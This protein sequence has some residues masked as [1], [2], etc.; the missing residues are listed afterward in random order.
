MRITIN[1][2][3]LCGVVA[4]ASVANN[5]GSST[6]LKFSSTSNIVKRHAADLT[7][8]GSNV[9]VTAGKVRITPCTDD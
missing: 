4:Q 7:F 6:Q 3:L 8:T 1:I 9:V 2:I 5:V